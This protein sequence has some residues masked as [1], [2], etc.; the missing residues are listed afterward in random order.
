MDQMGDLFQ[1]ICICA[2]KASKPRASPPP[3]DL[4]KLAAI[5]G[6]R[7]G[8]FTRRGGHSCGFMPRSLRLRFGDDLDTGGGKPR[9]R[10]RTIGA[11]PDALCTTYQIH[12]IRPWS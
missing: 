3:P 7:H 2:S 9:R 8:F 10:R 5:K 4:P 1:G 12:S 6:V 11:D